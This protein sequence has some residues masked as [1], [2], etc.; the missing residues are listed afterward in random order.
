MCDLGISVIFGKV[1]F[2]L[3]LSQPRTQETNIRNLVSQV[4]SPV[5]EI[6]E[7][8]VILHAHLLSAFFLIIKF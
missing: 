2:T 6:F 4:S 5:L 1:N 3:G 7:C 8:R